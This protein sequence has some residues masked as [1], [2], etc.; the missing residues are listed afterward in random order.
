MLRVFYIP[1]RRSSEEVRKIAIYTLTCENGLTLNLFFLYLPFL[2]G[3]LLTPNHKILPFF[4][5]GN[6]AICRRY[7]STYKYPSYMYVVPEGN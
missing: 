6:I 3:V 2:I 5:L 1:C 4:T 7:I